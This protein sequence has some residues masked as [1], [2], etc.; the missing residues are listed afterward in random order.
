V[1]PGSHATEMCAFESRRR[2]LD[3]SVARVDDLNRAG[4]RPGRSPE[5]YC[6][7]YQVSFPYRGLLVRHIGSHD[8]VGDANQ[9][10]FCRKGESFS[11]TAPVPEGY[12]ALIIT[13]SLDVLAEVMHVDGHSMGDHPLFKRRS[14]P[15]DLRLQQYP[16]HLR[17]WASTTP[18]VDQLAAEESV[19][20]L[21]RSVCQHGGRP[22]I[23]PGAAVSRLIRRTKEFLAAE[24]SSGVRLTDVA[25]V[26][27]ASPAYLTDVFRRVEGLPVHRYL[28]QLRLA[29]ALVELPHASDLTTLALNLGFSSHSHFSFAFRRAFGVTPSRFRERV[30]RS[31]LPEDRTSTDR[32]SGPSRRPRID[33]RSLDS[34]I[35]AEWQP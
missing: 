7:D 3:L 24:L 10:M 34:S 12:A 5:I 8:S 28:T 33:P 20:F 18:H 6:S 29:R 22:Y 19:L 17:H 14:V 11:V 9:V 31:P 4:I 23:R 25:R 35:S 1:I 27:G 16:S 32:Y 30:R 26:V 13:P 21:L 15:S 2:L